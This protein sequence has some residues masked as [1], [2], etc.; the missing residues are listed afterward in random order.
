MDLKERFSIS[1][2]TNIMDVL[3]HSGYTF[4]FAIADLIDNCIAAHATNISIFFDIDCE[5]PYLYIWDDG[6]GMSLKKL[7]EAATIGFENISKERLDDDLGRFST[8]LK[9]AAKSFCSNMFICSKVCNAEPNTIQL[10]FKHIIE[11][12]VWEAFLVS[13]F[14][15]EKKIQEHGTIIYCDH[16]S[17]LSDYL[18]P[19]NIYDK[20]DELEKAL[21]HIFG[22]YLLSN[23]LSIN[24]QVKGSKANPVK[25]WNP[26]GLL[27]NNSTKVIYS[28]KI[29]YGHSSIDI[30]AYVLPVFSNLD[31]V[32]QQYMNGKGLIDQQGF[33]IY[34]NSRLIQEGGWLN[35]K[36]LSLD[37]KSKYAR[38]EVNI[39]ANL[40]EDF[41]I[42]F[43]K[44]SLIIP[45]DLQALFLEVANKA[46]KESRSSANYL[47]HPELK[48][49][50]KVDENKIWQTSH[51]SIGTILTVNE[52]HPLILD[53]CK[54][55][56]T[57]EKKKLFSLLSKS[58]PIR[59]IQEQDYSV[60]G[61]SQNEIT[62]LTDSIYKKL[63]AKGCSLSEIKKQIRTMEPFKDYLEYV[64]E[65]FNNLEDKN[66]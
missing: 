42:N 14:S 29:K 24:I 57:A 59:S 6:D 22:K 45:D 28:N 53:V 51:S 15:L 5:T 39:P 56:T 63:S 66:D 16:L 31:T 7:K 36:G 44:N 38:I 48:K 32:D 8:G 34:R 10:D 21:S 64:I 49:K 13:N 4:N 43:S 30:N 35:L 33:Y 2:S 61:Y 37:E 41:K 50:M 40:D 25:G 26:F 60:R 20:I 46:R 54:K 3:G 9:S 23:Q 19:T 55:M 62:E 52:E 58:L 47:K 65:Y 11:K 18:L 27:H 1:P 12:N 17:I